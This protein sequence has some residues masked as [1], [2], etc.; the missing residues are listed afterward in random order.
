VLKIDLEKKFFFRVLTVL[1]SFLYKMK[2]MVCMEKSKRNKI[3]MVLVS[4]IV[5]I[6]LGGI[7]LF[8]G[9]SKTIE[10][11]LDIRFD[12]ISSVYVDEIE[13]PKDEFIKNYG[14]K[15]YRIKNLSDIG[16]T[17]HFTFVCYDSKGE[18]IFTLVDIGNRG[19]I[20]LQ[21][22]DSEKRILYQLSE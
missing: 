2:G 16:N 15:K 14:K 9:N 4:V 11:I 18:V 21:K 22:K 10:E 5:L 13:Y 12:D 3:I 1:S 6:I 20:Y 19:L 7:L 17:T 8:Y